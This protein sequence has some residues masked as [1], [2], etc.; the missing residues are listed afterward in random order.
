[1][2]STFWIILSLTIVIVGLGIL[3][4]WT[5]HEV[6]QDYL[7]ETQ[8]LAQWVREGSWDA[9]MERLPAL[10]KRWKDT[11]RWLQIFINHADTD[12][13]N[14]ALGKLHA[15]VET[16]DMPMSLWALEE[17]EEAFRHLY[18]RDAVTLSNVL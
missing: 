6:S 10:S 18:H 8:V 7:K 16:R 4:T 14:L 12:D 11:C 15:G 17:L 9:A 1:M 3:S 5:S 13:V 2:K